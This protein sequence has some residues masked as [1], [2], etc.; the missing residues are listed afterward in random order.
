MIDDS[1]PDP[2]FEEDMRSDHNP[3]IDPLKYID[4]YCSKLILVTVDPH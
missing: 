3:F 1:A 2:S 4:L